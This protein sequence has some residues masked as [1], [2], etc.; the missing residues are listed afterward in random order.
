MTV[1]HKLR[2]F[3]TVGTHE[4]GFPRLL[5]AVASVALGWH[6]MGLE[7]D[8]RVQTGSS[9]QSLPSRLGAF[10]SCTHAEILDHLAW[11][12]VS[13]S[14][15]APG[16]VYTAIKHQA[17]PIVMPRLY[18]LHE[19]VDDHQEIFARCVQEL[20]LA[21]VVTDGPGLDRALRTLAAEDPK[22]RQLHLSVLG[23]ESEAR[24]LAWATRT[25]AAIEQLCEERTQGPR[26]F[27]R[28]GRRIPTSQAANR[29]KP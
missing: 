15:C 1:Q 6:E 4:A 24:S 26:L 22:E 10:D 11:A 16:S 2:V 9:T 28:L 29:R 19:H 14:Q 23:A 12:D 27:G 20:A 17:Q 3:V 7:A 5:D 18:T 21:V 13:V 25:G 8:W